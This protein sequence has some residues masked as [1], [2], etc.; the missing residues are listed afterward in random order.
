MRGIEGG[1]SLE[2]VRAELEA[3]LQVGR[4]RR[5]LPQSAELKMDGYRRKI[6]TTTSKK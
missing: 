2:Q 1:M 4:F 5:R 6:A 3:A